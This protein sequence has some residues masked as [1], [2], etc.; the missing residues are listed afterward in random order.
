MSSVY[1]SHSKILKGTPQ[2]AQD[3]Q[4]LEGLGLEVDNPFNS[5]Y[6]DFWEEE[7]INFGLTLIQNNEYF[8]FRAMPDGRIASGVGK[9]VK[10]AINLNKPIIEMP[11]G[12]KSRIMNLDETMEFFKE[13]GK[14]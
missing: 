3:I 7:G 2:E 4:L 14:K 9:E 1:Y 5:I 11:F 12:L 10:W 8:A 6:T 13:V